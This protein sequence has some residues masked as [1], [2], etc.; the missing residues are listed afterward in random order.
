[1]AE[2]AGIDPERIRNRRAT[3]ELNVLSRLPAV[4][5]ASR[6]QALQFL[7][8][9]GGLSVFEWRTL[10]DI[11]E[12]GPM[13]IR[14]LSVIQRSDHSLLSRGLSAMRD[15]G[16]ITMVRNE[17]DKRQMVVDLTERGQAAYRRAAPIMA[18]RRA[19]LR[20]TMAEEDIRTL[21]SLLEK[22]EAFLRIPADHILEMEIAS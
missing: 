12:G 7:K 21:I 22:L 4:Y 9:G 11:S 17:T 8:H 15:K 5:A 3:E 6:T 14:D 13:T 10:W 1:M 18:R 16:Y 19:A 2:H 20:E